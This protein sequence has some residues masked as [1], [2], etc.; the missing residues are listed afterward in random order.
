MAARRRE[1]GWREVRVRMTHDDSL[2]IV[3]PA[4]EPAVAFGMRSEQLLYVHVLELVDADR[5]GAIL[6]LG[7][8]GWGLR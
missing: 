8:V 4:D 5:H 2:E 1:V 6:V 7:R 3:A